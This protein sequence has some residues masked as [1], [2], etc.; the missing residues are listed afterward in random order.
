MDPLNKLYDLYLTVSNTV[1]VY[2]KYIKFIY[3]YFNLYYSLLS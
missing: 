1:L 3:L 2:C